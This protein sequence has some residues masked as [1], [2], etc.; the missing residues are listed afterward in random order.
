MDLSYPIGRFQSPEAVGP[1]ERKQHIATIAALP[2]RLREAVAG[3]DDAQLDTPYRRGGWTVRQL[4]HHLADSHVNSYIRFRMALTEEQPG[5]TAY[6]EKKWA[7]LKDASTL[8]VE[9]SL[10]LLEALHLRWV[11]LLESLSDS[12]FLKTYSHPEN[13]IVRL[14]RTVALYSWH[15]KHHV[16]HIDGLKSRMGW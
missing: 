9:S 15:S 14:D 3:L 6:D 12:D 13:G 2:A 1:E 5:I 7:E 8:P 11:A 4:V 16:A 10:Q